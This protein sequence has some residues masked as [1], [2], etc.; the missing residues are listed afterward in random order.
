MIPNTPTDVLPT[1]EAR[2]FVSV[3]TM[4]W[5]DWMHFFL[6]WPMAGLTAL[7]STS[8]IWQYFYLSTTREQFLW[9]GANTEQAEWYLTV[10]NICLPAVAI[11]GTFLFSYINSKLVVSSTGG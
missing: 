2:R 10:L 4:M 9:L 7:A 5:R 6:S 8:F 11:P 3:K 1:S